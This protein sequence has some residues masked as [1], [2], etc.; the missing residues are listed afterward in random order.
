VLAKPAKE[1][2]ALRGRVRPRQREGDFKEGRKGKSMHSKGKTNVQEPSPFHLDLTANKEKKKDARRR[3]EEG[4]DHLY[5]AL[6]ER[7]L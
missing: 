3:F 2:V 6:I 7:S 1:P 5:I 4:G